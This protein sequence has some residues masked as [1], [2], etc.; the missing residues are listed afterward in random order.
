MVCLN[1][2]LLF[3]NGNRKLT[4][5][6]KKCREIYE[7]DLSLHIRMM[8]LKVR[9]KEEIPEEPIDEIIIDNEALFKDNWEDVKL[10]I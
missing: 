8:E 6:G 3:F 5:K 9:K 1:E 7:N 10:S 2:L 4:I